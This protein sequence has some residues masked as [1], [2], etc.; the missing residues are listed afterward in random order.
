MKDNLLLFDDSL[1]SI[2]YITRTV[3]AGE[4]LEMVKRYINYLINKYSNLSTKH[5]AIFVEPLITTGYPDIVIIE[6]YSSKNNLWNEQRLKLDKNALKILF[7]I[8]NAKYTSIKMLSDILGFSEKEITKKINLLAECDLIHISK[9]NK[10][11]QKIKLNKYSGI[12]KIISIEAKIDK[13]KEA[14]Q[15]A[16]RNICFSTESYVL[17]NKSSC[18]SNII[19]E[20]K[21]MGVGIIL[22][23]GKIEQILKSEVRNYPTSYISLEFNEWINNYRYTRGELK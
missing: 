7:E 12:K 18:N 10:S 9:N 3:T 1:P 22:V 14:L 2:S 5:V 21:K 20:C 15:Q 23:N 17:L 6:Y 16:A 19:N 13:W 8:N 4:E 11:I